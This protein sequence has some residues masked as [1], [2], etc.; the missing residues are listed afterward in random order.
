MFCNLLLSIDIKMNKHAYL[1]TDENDPKM[2]VFVK[3]F[4]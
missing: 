2:T 4:E 1:G 3:L